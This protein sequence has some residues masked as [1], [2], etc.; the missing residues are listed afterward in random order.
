MLLLKIRA[1]V[2][3]AAWQQQLPLSMLEVLLTL[4]HAI[5]NLH[6][7]FIMGVNA[8]LFSLKPHVKNRLRIFQ[9]ATLTHSVAAAPVFCEHTH[10]H[11]H[12]Q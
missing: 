7:L 8:N 9:G 4:T 2:H 10:T 11:T 12:V 6:D 1:S 3:Y 5:H